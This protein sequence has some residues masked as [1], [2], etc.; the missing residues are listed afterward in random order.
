MT[1][2]DEF[3]DALAKLL[4]LR[5]QLVRKLQGEQRFAEEL[6]KVKLNRYNY[7]WV[8]GEQRYVRRNVKRLKRDIDQI[9]RF[10]A[11]LTSYRESK[12]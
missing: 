3:V 7:R 9:D 5:Q 12:D 1:T 10:V 6:A 4:A 11:N 2:L 8:D